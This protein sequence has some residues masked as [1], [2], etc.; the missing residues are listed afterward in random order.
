MNFGYIKR[1]GKWRRIGG[2]DSDSS[3]DDSDS[4]VG[5]SDG[6]SVSSSEDE[7]EEPKKDMNVAMSLDEPT[8]LAYNGVA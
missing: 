4:S 3:D 1:N 2:G 6:D 7:Q 8:R 5:T